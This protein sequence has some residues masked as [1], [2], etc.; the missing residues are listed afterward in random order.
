VRTVATTP[1]I[2]T[3]KM[4]EAM[5]LNLAVRNPQS[6]V[7]MEPNFIHQRIAMKGTATRRK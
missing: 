6:L 3:A 4:P 1:A 2:K 5:T 7:R